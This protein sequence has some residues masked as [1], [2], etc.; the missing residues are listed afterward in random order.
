[1]FTKRGGTT[2]RRPPSAT[3]H[4]PVLPPTSLVPFNLMPMRGTAVI[5]PQCREKNKIGASEPGAIYGTINRSSPKWI[6]SAAQ[7]RWGIQS[8]L[9]IKPAF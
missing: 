2:F 7:S 4:R 9:Q 6:N 8:C 3:L 1:M 5:E